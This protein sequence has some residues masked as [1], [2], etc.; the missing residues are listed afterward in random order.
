MKFFDIIIFIKSKKIRL[1]RFKSKK[2]D[3]KLFNLLNGQQMSDKMKA[4]FC[5]H[6]VVNEKY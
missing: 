4:K 5:D 1:R 3:K 6:V 2:G